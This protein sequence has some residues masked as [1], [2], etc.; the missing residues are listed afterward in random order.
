MAS[1]YIAAIGVVSSERNSVNIFKGRSPG[2]PHVF[3][4]LRRH[5]WTTWSARWGCTQ[6]SILA[7]TRS[8]RLA[9]SSGEY[10]WLI[11]LKYSHIRLE[12]SMEVKLSSMCFG[13]EKVSE[14]ESPGLVVSFLTCLSQ[15]LF[16][17]DTR[18]TCF[19][20]NTMAASFSFI[21]NSFF[22][23]LYL[24]VFPFFEYSLFFLRLIWLTILELT[25]P[26]KLE[27]FTFLLGQC[28][29][30][31]KSIIKS[32]LATISVESTPMNTNS[33]DSRWIQPAKSDIACAGKGQTVLSLIFFQDRLVGVGVGFCKD[34]SMIR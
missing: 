34:Y 25:L 15:E 11:E 26:S 30:R 5:W 17:F 14:I 28:W 10:S 1:L 22:S 4:P 29:L 32:N 31:F 6:G 12:D 24:G 9:V 21:F 3:F 2:T 8:G 16:L 33:Q 19:S 23:A 18:L 7:R 20:R 13:S 27:I